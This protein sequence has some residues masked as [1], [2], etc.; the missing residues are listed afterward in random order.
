MRALKNMADQHDIDVPYIACAGQGDLYGAWGQ[1]E[2]IV[3]AVNLYIPLT[4]RNM[5]KHISGYISQMETLNIPFMVAET[6]R[7]HFMLRRLLAGNAKLLGPYNQVAGTDFGFFTSVNN[8][9]HPLA[10]QTT[11]YD[12]NSLIDSFGRFRNEIH[13]ARLLAGLL[14]ITG[15]MLAGALKGEE[16]H[17]IVLKTDGVVPYEEVPV[18][19]LYQKNHMGYAVSVTNAGKDS[20]QGVLY[21]DDE[22]WP[23]YTKMEIPAMVSRFAFFNLDLSAWGLPGTIVFTSAEP[24][25]VIHGDPTVMVFHAHYQGEVHFKFCTQDDIQ[26]FVFVFN[27]EEDTRREY[28]LCN[29]KKIVVYGIPSYKAS[30]VS[31]VTEQNLI[32]FPH[33]YFKS[34][35]QGNSFD[36]K[37]SKLDVE[38]VMEDMKLLQVELGDNAVAMEKAGF[39]RG[40]GWYSCYAH[41]SKN[42][43]VMGVLLHGAADV[44]SV[45]SNGEYLGTEL[46]AGGYCYLPLNENKNTEKFNIVVRCEIWGHSNF[47]DVRKPA[48]R[49]DS[50]RGVEG[51]TVVTCRKLLPIWNLSLDYREDSIYRIKTI[52][53]SWLTTRKPVLCRYYQNIRMSDAADRFIMYFDGIGCNACVE[54]DGQVAGYADEFNQY[55]DISP[56]VKKGEIHEIAI[57]TAKRYYAQPAGQVYLLQGISTRGWTLAGHPGEGLNN[58]ISKTMGEKA[59]PLRDLISVRPGNIAW[60]FGN[61][62]TNNKSQ[63]YILQ[64]KGKNAKLTVFFNDK[65]VGRIWLPSPTRPVMAGGRDDLAYLPGCWFRESGE[66]KIDIMIEAVEKSENGILELIQW[67][68]VD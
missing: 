60:L 3:P 10:L 24:I 62:Q 32:Y 11:N 61:I 50:L 23:K 67:E 8:W 25:R 64:F 6:G 35:R 36:I 46:P 42:S 33:E 48:L 45:Y 37:W 55:V 54:V 65:V 18:L 1:V 29:G 53:G 43:R 63:C 14:D 59:E 57:N 27:A 51:I 39:N 21:K 38:N 31:K 44:V 68:P 66:N 4:M 49:I 40:Y 41:T 34:K 19:A 5:E 13:E 7:E 26:E 28:T 58:E 16:D 30:M 9:G 22:P 17:G 15:Q 47:D 56:Y 20:M 52:F 2:G 12:F